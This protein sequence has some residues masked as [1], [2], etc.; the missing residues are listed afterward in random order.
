MDQAVVY[1]GPALFAKGQAYVALSRVRSLD[2][3]RI[4]ELDCSKL[5]GKTPCN[6]EVIKKMERMRQLN[7]HGCSCPANF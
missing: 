1:L 4:M 5:T 7:R 3:L 6:K 2:G